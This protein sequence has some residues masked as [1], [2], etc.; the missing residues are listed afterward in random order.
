MVTIAFIKERVWKA[1][2][3]GRLCTSLLH[4]RGIIFLPLLFFTVLHGWGAVAARSVYA[5]W[6]HIGAAGMFSIG[7]VSVGAR[8]GVGPRV[9]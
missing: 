1:K 2:S 6:D 5:S 3:S 4:V 7:V 8:V 9:S